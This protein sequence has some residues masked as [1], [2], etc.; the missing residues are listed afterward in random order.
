MAL[1]LVITG[2]SFAL[3]LA[4]RQISTTKTKS[5]TI[6]ALCIVSAVL[7]GCDHEPAN[8]GIVSLRL[9]HSPMTTKDERIIHLSLSKYDKVD[10]HKGQYRII[11]G[12]T[13][14][15]SIPAKFLVSKW[16]LQGGPQTALY[17][18]TR[19]DTREPWED[20][21]DRRTSG[22][23]RLICLGEKGRLI[24]V[25]SALLPELPPAFSPDRK[26][27]PEPMQLFSKMWRSKTGPRL[28]SYQVEYYDDIWSKTKPKHTGLIGN[29]D[30]Y[31]NNF[32]LRP[33]EYG[34]RSVEIVDCNK[35]QQFCKAYLFYNDFQV[36]FSIQKSELH[37][38]TS[39]ANDVRKLLQ[40]FAE[41]TR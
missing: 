33:L 16:N 28:G 4:W 41:N 38:I 20:C 39:I 9:A 3:G 5:S 1:G 40:T 30:P 32:Y 11:P 25:N 24:V 14:R 31:L 10:V 6:A 13:H 27:F 21:V 26:T 36:T 19:A 34:D 12:T 23:P 15:F 29:F 2:T 17:I 8:P 22:S 37:Q 35:V 18:E 7:S